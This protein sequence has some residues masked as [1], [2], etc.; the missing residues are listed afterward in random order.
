MPLFSGAMPR[1]LFLIYLQ[2]C[3]VPG[4]RQRGKIRPLFDYDNLWIAKNVLFEPG[5]IVS[6]ATHPWYVCSST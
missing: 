6:L 1:F 5:D 3:S 2:P 4:L